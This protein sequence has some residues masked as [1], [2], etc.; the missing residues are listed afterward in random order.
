MSTAGDLAS[1]EMVVP[2]ENTFEQFECIARV[3]HDE[4]PAAARVVVVEDDPIWEQRLAELASPDIQVADRLEEATHVIS[5]EPESS[6]ADCSG[7]SLRIMP[8]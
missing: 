5:V 3:M 7:L 6:S 2:A 8:R 4:L 1:D